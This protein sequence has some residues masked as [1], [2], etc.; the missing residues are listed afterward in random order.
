[1][2]ANFT[3]DQNVKCGKYTGTKLSKYMDSRCFCRPFCKQMEILQETF[4]DIVNRWKPNSNHL[5]FI[6]Q[7]IEKLKVI[8][9]NSSEYC[10]PLRATKLPQYNTQVTVKFRNPSPKDADF[11]K[12]QNC[13]TWNAESILGRILLTDASPTSKLW[14]SKNSR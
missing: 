10:C 2:Y 7:L 12:E 3:V 1:M 6:E 4:Y 14:S 5:Q 8:L 9:V 11:T 13:K